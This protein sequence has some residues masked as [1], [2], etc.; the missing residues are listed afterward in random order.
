MDAARK[1]PE[2]ANVVNTFRR[3]RAGLQIDMDLDK[4]QTM[5]VPVTDAYNTL[6]TFLGGLYVNDF[7]RFSHT[8]QVLIQ[9]EPEF[10]NQPSDIDRFYV[11]SAD[12]NM[13]P[14]GT[15]ASI[16][17][18]DRPRGRFPLQPFPRDPDSGRARAG[19]EP[20]QAVDVME[21]VAAQ[22]ACRRATAMNGPAPRIS[23]SS[24]KDTRA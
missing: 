2:I 21:K 7:N 17:P 6:Q 20:G 9:A 10:R 11:R 18:T 14:L 24:R 5:G 15:L 8:W 12:G 4:L 19:R 23:R 22:N 16:T 3:Q 1:R 13:V